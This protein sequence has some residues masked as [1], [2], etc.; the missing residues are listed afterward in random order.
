ME[1][2][3]QW[4]LGDGHRPLII[5]GPCSAETSEQM[6]ETA[7][8]VSARGIG[9][10]RA[11]LWKPRTRPGAFEGVGNKGIPMMQQVQSVTGLKVATE[12]AN[13]AHAQ[14]ALQAGFDVVW[15]GAR[16]TANPFAVQE[17]A[18]VLQGTDI[19]V[20]V[21]NPLNPDVELWVGAIERL[22]ESDI[23]KVGAIHRGFS[24]YEKN[25]F[26][27]PPMW[28]IP[29]ELR[30]RMPQLPML[31]DPSHIAGKRELLQQVAQKAMDLNFDGLMIETHCNPA[32]ALS[33]P[34]QQITPEALHQM[35]QNLVIRHLEADG[36]DNTTLEELRSQISCL[37]NEMLAL[38]HKR[39]TFVKAIGQYKKKHNI[40][41][42][43]PQRWNEIITT[44]LH[45]GGQME[46]SEAFI[47]NLFKAIHDES[48]S[49]QTRVMN[50]PEQAQEE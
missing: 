4:G 41:I 48:I 21:K 43:Q 7:S 44:G 26:R 11:G 19:P 28:Q 37:D 47:N 14:A 34:Q 36:A 27:N 1:I 16:T 49:T 30:R 33:D 42:L 32:A 46:L 2:L 38:L 22:L 5:A 15:I 25:L 24:L 40:T 45:T 3:Q 9:V 6:L 29:I 8:G 20:F 23:R 50:Q 35:L 10:F 39:M 17:I 18:H 31:C 12:V 13:A